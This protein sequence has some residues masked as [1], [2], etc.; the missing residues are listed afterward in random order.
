M[1][2]LKR[3][4]VDHA[5]GVENRDISHH[6]GPQNATIEDA[7]LEELAEHGFDADDVWDIGAIAGFFALSNRFAHVTALRPNPE[8]HLLGR[9]PR[10]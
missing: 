1:R 7:H 10:G 5:R 2:L 8:F 4:V 6:A 9:V 3:G